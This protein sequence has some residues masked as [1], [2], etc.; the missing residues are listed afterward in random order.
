MHRTAPPDQL[1]AEALIR[2]ALGE[3]VDI[4]GMTTEKIFT[5]QAAILGYAI[6]KLALGEPDVKELILE[7]ERI[8]FEQ[9]WK[10]PLA[11]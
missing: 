11:E 8:A 6:Q 5:T 2:D 4:S 3:P 1:E 7:S 9:G 10:P